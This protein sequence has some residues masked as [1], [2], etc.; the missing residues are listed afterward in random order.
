MT[1]NNSE[2]E[3]YPGYDLPLPQPSPEEIARWEGYR[4][5]MERKRADKGNWLER[6]PYVIAILAFVGMVAVTLAIGAII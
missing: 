4:E 5:E 3:V 6:H 1:E 2:T